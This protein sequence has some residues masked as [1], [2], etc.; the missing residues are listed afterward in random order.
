MTAA[1]V[2][3]II[4]VAGLLFAIFIPMGSFMFLVIR[5]YYRRKKAENKNE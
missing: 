1:Y 4:S 5:E 2:L 3:L